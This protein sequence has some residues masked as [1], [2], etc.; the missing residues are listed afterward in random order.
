MKR[1]IVATLMSVSLL[2]TGCETGKGSRDLREPTYKDAREN[3]FIP[4]NRAAAQQ[5]ISDLLAKYTKGPKLLLIASLVPI[6]HLD[7]SS[8]FGR[9]VS[10]QISAEFTRNGFDMRELKLRNIAGN[11]TVEITNEGELMLSRN[12][13]ELARGYGAQ[14]VVVGSYA[15]SRDFI[16]VNLKV[17]H[18]DS[19]TVLAVHDYALPMDSNNR[20]LL[21]R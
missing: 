8:N 12:V 14:A 9:I 18:P 13:R 5:L 17:I 2:L 3:Q 21:R 11:N 7:Q 19:H 15:E 1:V 4:V 20:R 16:Y 10:E 6:D